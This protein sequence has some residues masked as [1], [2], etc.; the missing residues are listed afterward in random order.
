MYE[1]GIH[2]ENLGEYPKALHYLF[3]ALSLK[4]TSLKTYKAIARVN[5][6]NR[7]F[8]NGLDFYSKAIA[9]FPTNAEIYALKADLHRKIKEYDLAIKHYDEAIK[10][11][12]SNTEYYVTSL[13]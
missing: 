13:K 5:R 2:K 4:G 3:Y 7:Q 12:Y 8:L 10:L 11:D 1:K 9:I 6:K